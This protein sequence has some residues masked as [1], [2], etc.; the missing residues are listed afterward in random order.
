M[1]FGN[2]VGSSGYLFNAE[3][4]GGLHWLTVSKGNRKSNISFS[5]GYGYLKTEFDK[6]YGPK[7]SYQNYDEN[8]PYFIPYE[9]NMALSDELY[10]GNDY[11]ILDNSFRTSLVFG[12]AGISPV[13]KKASF[14]FDSM[15]FFG[16]PKEAVY[17]DKNITLTYN[18]TETDNITFITTTEEVTNSFT[19][20]EGE[21]AKSNKFTTTILLMPGMRFN[22][23]HD[24]AIQVTLSGF[25]NIDANG[26]GNTVPM[27]MVSWLRQ[28]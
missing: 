14:I 19:I 7:Y 5:T 13:G 11:S 22:Q 23:T 20:Q 9:A 2:I 27:P 8:E 15:D 21:L 6:R 26:N 18:V 10:T 17:T 25:I 28:F 4:V 3:G 1:S 24:K 12:V 16:R